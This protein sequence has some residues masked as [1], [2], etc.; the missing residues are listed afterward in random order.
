MAQNDGIVSVDQQDQ[1]PSAGFDQTSQLTHQ[2]SAVNDLSLVLVI[3]T[4]VFLALSIVMIGIQLY[5]IYDIGKSDQEI[6]KRVHSA[7]NN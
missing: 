5:T 1:E 3:L 2:R 4:T 6:Q 7:R